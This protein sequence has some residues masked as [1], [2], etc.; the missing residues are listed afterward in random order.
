MG[1]DTHGHTAGGWRQVV[2]GQVANRSIVPYRRGRQTTGYAGCQRGQRSRR[3]KRP[4]GG[5]PALPR[6]VAHVH[7]FGSEEAVVCGECSFGCQ[8]AAVELP[9]HVLPYKHGTAPERL[10]G[11][12]QE[13]SDARPTSN[14][15]L[16]VSEGR[17]D[18]E[19]GRPHRCWRFRSNCACLR[20]HAGPAL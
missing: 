6:D 14:I 5:T 1:Q 2:G 16:S 3:S 18:H 15:P 17:T 9:Y 10:E 8:E 12:F 7:M 19:C 11:R 4:Q 20:S 13:S